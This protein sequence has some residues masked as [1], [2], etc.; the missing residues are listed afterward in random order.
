VELP[1]WPAGAPLRDV[2]TGRG[3]DFAAGPR[4]PV[5]ALLGTLPCAAWVC[6]A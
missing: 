2:L 3:V 5:A 6:A 1:N 4:L